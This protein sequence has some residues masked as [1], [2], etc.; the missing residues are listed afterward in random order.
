MYGKK[1]TGCL[2]RNSVA[3]AFG[4]LSLMC[5][6]SL[7]ATARV[8][9]QTTYI[10]TATTANSIGDFTDLSV[11]DSNPNTIYFVTSNWNPPS[12]GGV[13]NHHPTE[14]WFDAARNDWAIFNQDGSPIPHGAAFNVWVMK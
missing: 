14:V 5:V 4:A 7:A 12:S 13:Y 3:H 6:C 2:P 9:A 10:Q 1:R 8:E 11:K